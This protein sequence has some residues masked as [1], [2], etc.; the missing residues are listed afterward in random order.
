MK[1]YLVRILLVATLAVFSVFCW[2][3]YAQQ[4]QNSKVTWEYKVVKTN[5]DSSWTLSELGR[6]GWEL[7]S[8]RPEEQM[9]GNVRQTQVYYY[10]KRST[11]PAK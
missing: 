10:L 11:D 5:S 6:D 8:V 4:R 3:A 2:T 7:V 1:T 9:I